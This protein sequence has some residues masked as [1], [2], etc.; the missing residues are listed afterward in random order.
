[1]S[2]VPDEGLPPLLCEHVP[3][4]GPGQQVGH[5]ALAQSQHRLAEQPL[6]DGVLRE[7]LL[8]P[9]HRVVRVQVGKV[10][11]LQNIPLLLVTR[12]S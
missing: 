3:G 10:I 4:L 8:Y 11:K 1:M 7:N 2:T 6:G 5:G 9:P 12:L